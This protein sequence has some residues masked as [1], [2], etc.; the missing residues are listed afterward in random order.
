MTSRIA[1]WRRVRPETGS[2]S[3][4]TLGRPGP[5]RTSVAVLTDVLAGAALRAVAAV[6]VVG[7]LWRVALVGAAL[8]WGTSP[9]GVVRFMCLDRSRRSVRLQTSV[10]TTR[11]VALVIVRPPW[12]TFDQA[13]YRMTVRSG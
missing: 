10:R 12:Y 9:P 2:G 1:C 3:S 8:F 4:V 11:R 6:P 13:F 7:L 5:R